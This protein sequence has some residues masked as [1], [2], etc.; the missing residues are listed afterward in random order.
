M[1]IY[2]DGG[3]IVGELA[4]ELDIPETE[5]IKNYEWVHQNG[6][7]KMAQYYDCNLEDC[8]IGFCVDDVPVSEIT[9]E[10]LDNVKKLSDRFEKLLG[11][12]ARLIGTQD[13]W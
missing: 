6:L 9:G 7:D 12:P 4:S 3:M 2:Y 1:G 5:E 10:W 8:Y 13:I 11:V